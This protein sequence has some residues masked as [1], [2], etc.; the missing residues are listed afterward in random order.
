MDTNQKKEKRDKLTN[1]LDIRINFLNQQKNNL[2]T[3]HDAEVKKLQDEI[4]L[5]QLQ[6]D[7]LTNYKIK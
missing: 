1:D 5:L 6:S 7:A 4:D 2:T 3:Q